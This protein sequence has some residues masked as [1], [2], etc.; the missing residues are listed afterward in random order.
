MS[1]LRSRKEIPRWERPG[2]FG[3]GR[4]SLTIRGE[5]KVKGVGG[6]RSMGGGR[7]RRQGER[8]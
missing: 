6:K 7:D 8:R 3:G 1:G 5:E 2:Q 4:V